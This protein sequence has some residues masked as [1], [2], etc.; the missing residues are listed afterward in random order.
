M[1]DFDKIFEADKISKQERVERT[2]NHQPVDRVAIHDQVSYNPGVI[3]LYAGKKIDGFNY[4]KEDICE[5]IR[6]TLDMC[7]PPAAP[8]GKNRNKSDDGFVLQNDNWTS[9]IV[10][11]PFS[12]E[13][14]AC[15][16]LKKKIDILKTEKFN[17]DTER[18]L[19]R[20]KIEETKSEIGDTVLCYHSGFGFSVWDMMGI[21]IFTFFVLDYPEIMEEHMELFVKRKIKWIE[22]VAE[23]MFSPVVLIAE[24]FASKNGPLFGPDIM[25]KYHYKYL[26]ILTKKWH[27]YGYKVLFHSDGNW[28]KVIP[29]L[30]ATGVDGF[31]CLE[32]A[33]GMD[34][35]ELKKQYPQMIWAG[36]LDG[37]DLMEGGAPEQ[38]RKEVIRHITETDVLHA[39]GMFLASSSEIN[40]PI[41]PENFKAM[42]DA[43]GECWNKEFNQ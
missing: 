43:A 21:D 1:A 17:L 12:N 42:I 36:G 3:E 27:S 25:N 16:W 40:P 34:I 38:V 14:G 30:I 15:D 10:E 2:L 39:G 32:P 18:D 6:K 19:F 37:V 29:D 5:V 9:W 22:A 24:D 33:V 31:Y 28:K 20:N 13:E 7:F 11:R 23:P 35:V 4:T 26:K 8:R 41:K